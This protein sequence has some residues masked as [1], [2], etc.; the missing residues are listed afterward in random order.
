MRESHALLYRLYGKKK[1]KKKTKKN[2]KKTKKNKTKK[3]LHKIHR[4]QA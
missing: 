4:P 3:V 2:E 1:N